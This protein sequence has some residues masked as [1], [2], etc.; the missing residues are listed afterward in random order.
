MIKRVF[1]FTKVR[2]RGSV[3]NGNRVFVT[4]ALANIFLVRYTLQRTLSGK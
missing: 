4:V 2:Y 3:K 1:G